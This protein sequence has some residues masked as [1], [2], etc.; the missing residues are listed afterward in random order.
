MVGFILASPAIVEYTLRPLVNPAG[1]FEGSQ[2]PEEA[3]TQW[4]T[5]VKI[6]FST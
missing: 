3:T 1:N 5:R 2:T 4:N 6:A